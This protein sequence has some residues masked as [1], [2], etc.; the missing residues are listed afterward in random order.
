MSG[1]SPFHHLE[2]R[3]AD[4]FLYRPQAGGG[5]GMDG[6]WPSILRL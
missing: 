6:R 2:M 3:V 5:G 1:A 4:E